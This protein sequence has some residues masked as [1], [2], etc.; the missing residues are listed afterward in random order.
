M[1]PLMLHIRTTWHVISEVAH[2]KICEIRVHFAVTALLTQTSLAEGRPQGP[3][4]LDP[5]FPPPSLVPE[6]ESHRMFWGERRKPFVKFPQ[7]I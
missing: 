7:Y 5:A 3:A 1:F 2:T 6:C 4:G